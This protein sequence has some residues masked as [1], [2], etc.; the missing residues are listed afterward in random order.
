[1]GIFIPQISRK[2]P[3]LYLD[4]FSLLNLE[5]SDSPVCYHIL[6]RASSAVILVLPRV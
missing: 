1:M 5:T 4:Q 6:I 3:Y 2:F